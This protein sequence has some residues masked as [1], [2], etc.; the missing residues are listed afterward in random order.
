MDGIQN[1]MRTRGSTG[2]KR[3]DDENVYLHYR[4]NGD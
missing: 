2:T 3:E 4:L 1:R